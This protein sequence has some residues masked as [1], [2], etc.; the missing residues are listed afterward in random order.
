M[1]E[2]VIKLSQQQACILVA[3]L[4]LAFDAA[5]ESAVE[6]IDDLINTIEEQVV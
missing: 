4:E 6:A 3:T 2:V 1:D 5:P